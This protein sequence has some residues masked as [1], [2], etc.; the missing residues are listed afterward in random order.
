MKI[1]RIHIASFGSIR[2][3]TLR[4]GDGLTVIYGPNESGKTSLKSFVT[5]TLFPDRL[6]RYPAPS[7][8]DSGEIDIVPDGGPKITVHRNGRKSD[9]PVPDICK[10]GAAEYSSIYSLDPNDLRDMG[11]IMKGG[12]REK[13]LSVPGSDCIPKVISEIA[14][15]KTTLIPEGRRSNR[16]IISL[17]RDAVKAA[18]DKVD[19]I[20]YTETGDSAYNNLCAEESR[21]RAEL[22]E[23][24]NEEKTALDAALGNARR[25]GLSDIRNQISALNDERKRYAYAEKVNPSVY[26]EVKTRLEEAQARFDAS[27]TKYETMNSSL[28]RDFGN[29]LKLSRRISDFGVSASQTVPVRSPV[30]RPLLV[31]GGVAAVLGV[32]IMIDYGTVKGLIVTAIGIVIAATAFIGRKKRGGTSENNE[33]EWKSLCSDVGIKPSEMAKDAE[34]MKTILRKA[35]ETSAAFSDSE[36]DRETLES[37]KAELEKTVSGFGISEDAEQAI[38]DK[39]KLSRIDAQL[40]VLR[41]NVSSEIP[42][43]AENS[44]FDKASEKTKEL[45]AELSKITE[46][47]RAILSDT[48]TDSALDMLA[49]K[50]NILA[51]HIREWVVLALEK[52]ILDEA[53]KKSYDENHSPAFADGNRY[54]EIMTGGKYSLTDD[55]N[56]ISVTDSETEVH[57][58]E[59]MW[60]T[61][62]GD[63]V[64][65]SLKMGVARNLCADR[66][67]MIL[68]DVLLTSDEPRKKGCAKAIADLAAS[69]Q[70][71]YFTCS[72]ESRDALKKEGAHVIE[73]KQ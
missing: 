26:G 63:Q 33:T 68:D 1:E 64:K 14:K 58:K 23:A 65:L 22:A 10:M 43:T 49:A 16:C 28:P 44:G 4:I 40:D 2:G 19:R 18:R 42:M 25:E 36:H 62:T 17:D 27:R 66:P 52:A 51:G 70:I 3:I 7:A 9:S 47:R 21:I 46:R 37:R 11:T 60:T 34:I 32:A 24:E 73:L 67:P 59:D 57:K 6:P 41:K 20:R 55:G 38:S 61:G 31:I 12:I 53:C 54:L 71:I 56:D 35:E 48:E 30:S 29:I 45:R 72:T 5:G 50:R 15:E 69:M 13:L 39:E 8:G